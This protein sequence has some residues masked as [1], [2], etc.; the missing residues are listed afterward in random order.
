MGLDAVEGKIHMQLTARVC[1]TCIF[2]QL[3]KRRRSEGDV[4]LER[5]VGRDMEVCDNRCGE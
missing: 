3:E 5:A 2:V 1:G 4:L